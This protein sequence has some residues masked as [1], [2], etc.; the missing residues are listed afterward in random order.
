MCR[1]LLKPSHLL[2]L[3]IVLKFT[4]RSIEEHAEAP[5][6]DDGRLEDIVAHWGARH[7]VV[8]HDTEGNRCFVVSVCVGDEAANADRKLAEIRGLVTAVGD[9]IVG[10][11]KHRLAKPEPRTFV[12]PGVC[13]RLG[14]EARAAGATMLVLDA[15]LSPSQLRN[16]EDAAGIAVCD[17]EAVILNVF[18]RHARTP[19]ARIQVEIAH[20]EYLRPRIRGLG[21]DM[22]QQ[23]GGVMYA[24]GPGEKKSELMARQL[25]GRMADLRK[26][27]RR[28]EQSGEIQRDGRAR[29]A[30][31]ALVGYTNAGKT[32]LMNAL[33]D[34]GLSARDM[35]FETLDTTS[36]CLTRHGGDVIVSDTVGFIRRLPERL[37]ASFESTLAEIRHASLVVVV[38]DASD[39]E[40]P[41]HL[42]TTHTMLAKLGADTLPRSYVFNKCDR[43]A[44]PSAR[45]LAP[46]VGEH[47]FTSLSAHDERA[48][49]ELRTQLIERLRDDHQVVR[50]FLPY[51][52]TEALSLAY[53]RCRVLCTEDKPHGLRITLSGEQ[54]VLERVRELGEGRTR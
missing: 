17:R 42:E 29:A 26:A 8:P 49:S 12:G 32:S 46:W 23:A 44:P 30:Q 16:L 33:T 7:E 20:L 18:L 28:L 13:A 40:W 2:A 34:A 31:I 6:P 5:K 4:S 22:D 36:R 35:P 53:G 47:S 3:E 54:R 50:L 52:A 37:L 27:L 19:R 43:A 11:R 25:D 15:E 45:E 51:D 24:R 39:E 9:A 14:D 21:L 48:V 38:V 10:S 1:P 41:L